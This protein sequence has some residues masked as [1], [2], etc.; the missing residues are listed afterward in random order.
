MVVVNPEADPDVFD[1]NELEPP[2]DGPDP[3]VLDT[4]EAAVT[5]EAFTEAAESE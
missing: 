5:G 1:V 2:P 3:E 4:T